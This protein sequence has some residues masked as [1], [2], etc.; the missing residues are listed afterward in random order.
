MHTSSFTSTLLQWIF[1]CMKMNP[2]NRLEIPFSGIHTI[3]FFQNRHTLRSIIKESEEWAKNEGQNEG[4]INNL[5]LFSKWCETTESVFSKQ[6]DEEKIQRTELKWMYSLC[7]EFIQNEWRKWN[8]QTNEECAVLVSMS[9]SHSFDVAYLHR[10]KGE[11]E[12]E[13][14]SYVTSVIEY[15]ML[16]IW[17]VNLECD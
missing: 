2:K 4:K 15:I 11:R 3:L 10:S 5:N 16:E 12:R 1:E 13:R 7:S 14:H 6:R 8:E 17:S 9:L